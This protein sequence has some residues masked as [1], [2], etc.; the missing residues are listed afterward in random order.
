LFS[1]SSAISAV[2]AIL[3]SLLYNLIY[4]F[5]LKQGFPPGS[6]YWLMAIIWSIPVPL[7]LVI[8]GCTRKESKPSL[9]VEVDSETEIDEKK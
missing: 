4:P 5:T 6:S 9:S 3:G 2:S 1:I 8:W 7:M